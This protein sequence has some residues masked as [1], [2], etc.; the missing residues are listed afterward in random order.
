MI[1]LFVTEQQQDERLAICGAC[2]HFTLLKFCSQCNCF[3]PVKTK[4]SSKKCPLDKWLSIEND[5]SD[6]SS[7]NTPK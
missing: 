3:M 4:I 7:I 6:H 2:E 5:P 1:D